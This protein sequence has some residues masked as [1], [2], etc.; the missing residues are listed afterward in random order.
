MRLA[1]EGHGQGGADQAADLVLLGEAPGG[2][3]VVH[4]AVEHGAVVDGGGLGARGDR[5]E[6]DIDQPLPHGPDPT[7]AGQEVGLAGRAVPQLEAGLH[8]GVLGTRGAEVG[9]HGHAH[10][11]ALVLGAPDGGGQAGRDASG[12]DD[13]RCGEGRGALDAGVGDPAGGAGLNAGDAAGGRGD[14]AGDRHAGQ[15]PGAGRGGVLGQVAVKQ[16]A[17]A[18][19]PVG[20]EGGL[21]RPG[22]V[23]EVPAADDAQS[24]VALPAGGV[25]P[26]GD[27]LAHGRGGQP[28][29]ADLVP[30]E[31]LLLQ[32]DDVEAEGGHVV[33]R[34]GSGRARPDDDDVGSGGGAGLGGCLSH[35]GFPPRHFWYCGCCRRHHSWHR[36][37][38]P[39]LGGARADCTQAA[40]TSMTKASRQEANNG[41]PCRDVNLQGSSRLCDR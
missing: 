2:R 22:E 40:D 37:A 9:A 18:G 26:H 29:P 41:F 5:A 33:G 14:G 13:Q 27:Q 36:H 34:R 30:A 31:L 25:H 20:R 3:D 32:Q 10:G 19:H 1:V 39:A 24:A 28:V 7:V 6:P 8:P 38:G 21:L 23:E 17:R 11:A 16:G 35:S 15:Q 4:P 12:V